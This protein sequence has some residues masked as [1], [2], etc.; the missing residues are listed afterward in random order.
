MRLTSSLY[1]NYIQHKI[2]PIKKSIFSLYSNEDFKKLNKLNIINILRNGD[3]LYFETDVFFP[4]KSRLESLLNEINKDR[5]ILSILTV[6]EIYELNKRIINDDSD[7]NFFFFVRNDNIENLLY[8]N[9]N[10]FEKYNELLL[11]LSPNISPKKIN[12]ILS[13]DK[14]VNYLPKKIFLSLTNENLKFNEYDNPL[15]LLKLLYNHKYTNEI[16]PLFFSK[17]M[18]KIQLEDINDNIKSWFINLKIV[19]QKILF[20]N[21]ILNEKQL[22]EQ[23]FNFETFGIDLDYLINR[24]LDLMNYDFLKKL[25][26]AYSDKEKLISS[27]KKKIL[28]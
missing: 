28:K 27:L 2:I 9:Q 19:N 1:P 6:D 17:L 12:Y 5:K 10:L 24:N 15:K 21:F 14:I 8:L 20:D 18:T 26:I 11:H 25:S 4:K 22:I 7:Y 23:T 13:N 16:N 3:F